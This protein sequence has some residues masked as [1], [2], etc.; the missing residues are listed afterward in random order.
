MLDVTFSEDSCRVLSENAHKTL[1]SLRKFA[2]AVHKQF[3][4]AHHK[5]SSLKSSM[6]SALLLHDYLLELLHFL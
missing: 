3:L 6:L 4:S 2:L 1:N 5:K